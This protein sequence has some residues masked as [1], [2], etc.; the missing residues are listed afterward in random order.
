MVWWFRA[1]RPESKPPLAAE[2]QSLRSARKQLQQ[3]CAA[4]DAAAA[5]NALLAWGQALIAPRRAAHLQQLAR[6]LGAELGE[7][8]ARLNRSLY[9][10]PPR[11]WRGQPLIELCSRLEAD[12]ER[13]AASGADN[14]LPLN[15]AG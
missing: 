12:G 9:A 13:P 10:D 5:R 8:I 7:E 4:N 6:Q 15:P 3:A 1:R 2:S 11:S 14:L